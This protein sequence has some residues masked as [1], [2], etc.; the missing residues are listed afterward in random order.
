MER[1]DIPFHVLPVT[2]ETKADEEVKLLKI[3]ADT[4]SE[5]VVLACYM[6]V[7]SDGLCRKLS[8]KAINIHHSFLPGFEARSRIV[9]A[10]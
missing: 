5:L 2:P 9:A 8:G 4:R 1:H 10:R 7:L 3:V 6:Q